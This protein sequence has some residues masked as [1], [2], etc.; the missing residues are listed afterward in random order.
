[1]RHT[2]AGQ[3]AASTV[4]EVQEVAPEVLRVAVAEAPHQVGLA[5]GL[6]VAGGRGTADVVVGV[7]KV[8]VAAAA[9]VVVAGD[10]VPLV[11]AAEASVVRMAAAVVAVA[12]V[13]TAVA[14][15]EELTRRLEVAAA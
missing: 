10:G 12:A 11:A 14:V 13:R 15:E 8:A 2:L 9:G 1:M 7:V 4:P 5:A 3:E 6:P